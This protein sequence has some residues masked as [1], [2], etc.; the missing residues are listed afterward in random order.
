M[1]AAR[2]QSLSWPS[3]MA[4]ER[5][6]QRMFAPPWRPKTSTFARPQFHTGQYRLPSMQSSRGPQ[7]NRPRAGVTDF[8][9]IA[10]FSN[11]R[12]LRLEENAA[13]SDIAAQHRG[14]EEPDLSEP[15]QHRRDGCRPGSG[16]DLKLSRAYVWGTTRSGFPLCHSQAKSSAPRG[17]HCAG[18]PRSRQ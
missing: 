12:R 4:A 9:T 10:G 8:K 7:Q 18:Q 14:P 11:L 3:F 15:D 13:I 6:Q 17:W 2:R 16:L 1:G 5:N